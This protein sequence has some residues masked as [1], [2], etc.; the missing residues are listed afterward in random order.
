[1]DG[2]KNMNQK[3]ITTRE[4]SH[5]LG[6]SEKEIIQL[7]QSNNIPHFRIGG[8]FLRFKKE[9]ILKIKPKIKKIYGLNED[10]RSFKN[11]AKEFLYF[12]D[13]YIG[14]AIIIAALVWLIVK[15]FF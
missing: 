5:E 11:R 13:F 7:A 15:D 14:S 9:D 8:E 12:N 6:L 2:Y 10:S 4:V 1:M 3:L